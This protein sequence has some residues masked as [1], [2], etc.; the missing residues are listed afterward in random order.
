MPSVCGSTVLAMNSGPPTRERRRAQRW[1]LLAA[2]LALTALLAGCGSSSSSSGNGVESKSATEIVAASRH[3]ATGATS[4]HVAGSV[5][6]E[7]KTI[8]IDLQLATGKG[9]SGSLTIDGQPIEI[10]EVGDS[11]YL[12]A[13]ESFYRQIG[14]AAAATLLKGKWLKAPLGSGEFAS[15][16]ALTNLEKLLGGT[17]AAH[18]SLTKSASTTINGQPAVGVSDSNRQGTLYVATTGPAYPVAIV[19]AGA[20]GGKIT[21]DKWNQPVTLKAPAGAVDLTNLQG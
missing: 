4:V 20:N 15:L 21:F 18:G 8:D 7:G 10:V 1:V 14:G 3:A 5:V 12:R 9:A 2:L 17:L 16:S 11:F 19:K 13:S 6:N